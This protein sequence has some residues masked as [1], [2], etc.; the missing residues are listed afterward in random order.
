MK[1]FLVQHGQAKSKEDDTQRSLNE[2]GMESTERV[3]M[4]LKRCKIKVDQ[5]LHSGKKRAEQTAEIFARHLLLEKEIKAHTCLKPNDD[6]RLMAAELQKH[7]DSLMLVGHLPFMSRFASFLLD[8]DPEKEIIR[9]QNSGVVCLRM[10]DGN[11][12][13]EWMVVPEV[14]NPHPGSFPAV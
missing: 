9:F 4:H 7:S 6:V 8:D 14:T 12:F 11:W 2:A 3:A 13:L 5:I 10:E 1:L